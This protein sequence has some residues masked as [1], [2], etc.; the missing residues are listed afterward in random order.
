MIFTFL[1]GA[2]GHTALSGR[3]LSAARSI[4]CPCVEQA[5]GLLLSTSKPLTQCTHERNKRLND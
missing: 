2:V 3:G 5:H 1:R 4:P